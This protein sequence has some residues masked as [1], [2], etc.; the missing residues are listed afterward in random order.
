M[1]VK[2]KCME[3]YVQNPPPHRESLEYTFDE[4]RYLTKQT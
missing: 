4:E 3:Q 1:M 2:I